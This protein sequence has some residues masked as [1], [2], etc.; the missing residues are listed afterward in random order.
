MGGK[1]AAN[2]ILT[3]EDLSTKFFAEFF[4]MERF[5]EL[6]RKCLHYK[7]DDDRKVAIFF[8]GITPE[9]RLVL[10]SVA[11]GSIRQCTSEQAL[12]LIKKLDRNENESLPVQARGAVIKLEGNDAMLVEQKLLSKKFDSLNEKF[13]KLQVSKVQSTS[14]VCEYCGEAH[15]SNEC[16]TLMGASPQ[17]VQVNGVWYEQKSQQIFKETRTLLL[18]ATFRGE[19]KEARAHNKNQDASIRNLEVQI[20]QLSKQVSERL[21]G[22][23]P[24]DTIMNSKENCKTIMTISGKVL[25]S[26][27]VEEKLDEATVIIK[28]KHK[29]SPG[30]VRVMAPYPERFKQDAQKQQYARF[31]DIFKKLHSNIP[32]AEA[33]ANM[34]NYSMFMKDLLSRK[35]KSQEC[36]TVTLTEECSAIIQKKFPQKLRDPGSFNISIAIGNTNVGRALCDLRASKN[37]MPLSVCKSLEISELKPTMVSLQLADRSLRK[38]NGIIE[39]VLVK[40]D[41]LDVLEEVVKEEKSPSQELEEELEARDIVS[42]EEEKDVMFEVPEKKDSDKK[43]GAPKIELKE[44]P[45]TLKY[46]FIW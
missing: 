30:Y 20:G 9:T 19:V 12:D 21:P 11:G 4:S 22:T 45:E 2:S 16:P 18:R 33:L 10:N 13:E 6:I 46:I 23:F 25:P 38:P 17:Q 24:S 36:Q 43:D 5:Q 42:F 15:E 7:G 27:E 8:N 26:P 44:L 14:V 37:L 3:W 29:M 41:K 31:L 32:F 39:D 35:H 34:P 40:V 1:A 28:K